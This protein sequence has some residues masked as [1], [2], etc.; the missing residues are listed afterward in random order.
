MG[1]LPTESVLW[2]QAEDTEIV[3]DGIDMGEG[4]QLSRSAEQY[5]A[6]ILRRQTPVSTGLGG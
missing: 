5:V 2:G 3:D 6:M 1:A 4:G